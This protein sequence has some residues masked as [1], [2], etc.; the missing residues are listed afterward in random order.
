MLAPRRAPERMP[1]ARRGAF[2]SAAVM[3]P[4][5]RA[6]AE[7][8][9]RA[10]LF[11]SDRMAQHGRAL[12]ASH[13]LASGR[14]P[15]RLLN[16]LAANEHALADA[17]RLLTIAVAENRRITPAGEW[18]LDNFYLIEEQ[19][20]TARRHLPKDYSRE[21]PRL[22]SGP[23]AG[24]PRVYDIALEAVAHGD[25]R[26][27]GESLSRFVAA[28][29]TVTVLKLGELWAIPIMLRLALIENLRR[30][31]V[32]IAA[33][34]VERDLADA[35]AERMTQTIETDPKNLILVVADMA[36]SHPPMSCTFVAEL[37][38][39]VQHRGPALALPL[40]WIEQQL[41]E[42]GLSIEQSIQLENQQQ[43]ADQV[44]I[45][46]S[47]GSL[48]LL[49]AMDWRTFVETLSAVELALR[50]DPAGIYRGMDFSTR[51]RYRHAVE[52]IA[53]RCALAEEEVARKAVELA[54]AGAAIDDPGAAADRTAHVGHYLIDK[55]LPALERAVVVR[56]SAAG[57]VRRIAAC[58]PLAL[59]LGAIAL[60][61]ALI[62]AGLLQQLQAAPVLG[63]A[64]A[65]MLLPPGI[66]A[67]L[68][69]S[70][71]GVALTNWLATLLVTPH[72]LPRMDFAAGIPPCWRTLVVVPT[73]LTSAEDVDDLI[74]ALEV[75]FLANRDQSLHFGLL[76]DLLDAPC[77]TLPEDGAL[78]QHARTGV[79]ALNRKYAHPGGAA[80]GDVFFL[81]HR[82]RR[83]NPQEGVWMGYERKRGK[84]T[85]LNALL[86]GGASAAGVGFALVV[87]NTASLAAVK[88]V[89]TLD[90][91]T[92]LPR[93]TARQLV[94][95]MAHPL[96]RPRYDEAACR[97]VD[98]YGILQPSVEVSL[99]G[100]NR[101]RYARLFG[102]EA[103]IDPYTHAVSDVYQDVFG[104]GS[105]IGKGIYD[106]DA[107]EQAVGGRFPENRIL[108]HDLLEGCYARAGRLSEVQLYED[109]P[110]TYCADV[111]RRHRW[112]RGDWQ[113]AGWLWRQ[114]PCL[115]AGGHA[116]P[117]ARLER[118]PLSAL[119]QWKLLDNLR[120]GLVPAA[121]VL[122]LL[123]GWT[124]LSPAGPWTLSVI[125]LLL[126]PAL[127]TLAVEL[128]RKAEEVRLR[129]HLATVAHSAARRF[130]QL[131]FELAC[132]PYEA[133]FSLDAIVRTLWRMGVTHRRLLEW[134]PSREAER[135]LAG[136]G[137]SD[138]GAFVRT[139]WVAPVV[140]AGGAMLVAL[141]NPAGVGVAAP[142]LLLW[143]AAPALAWWI[144]R[145]LAHRAPRLTAEQRLFLRGLSRRTWAFFDTFV[146]P[147]DHWLP[148]D[149][150]QEYRTAL[151]AHRTSP[152]NIGL[153]LLANLAAY[154]FGYLSAGRLAERTANT[155]RT[156]GTLERHR[157]H[158]YNWYDTQTLLPLLPRYI[159]TVDSGNL[160]GHLLTLRAGLL[161]L[162]NDPIVPV[163]LADGLS[164]TFAIVAGTD[165][166]AAAALAAFRRELAA[167]AAAPVGS[168]ATLRL[169]LLRLASAAAELVPLAAGKHLV[170][171]ANVPDSEAHDWA[172]ALVR[173]CREALDEVDFLAPWLALLA[174]P[175]SPKAGAGAAGSGAGF[176][177]DAP[178]PSLRA[179]AE[180]EREWCPAIGRR[181]EA[182]TNAAQRAWFGELRGHVAKGSAR[183]R[184]RLAVIEGLVRQADALAQVEYDFLFD[185]TRHLLAIGYNVTEGWAESSYYDLLASE[186]RLSTFVGIAQ[187]QL[188]Q[189]SWFALGRLL[190]RSAGEPVLLSWS[191]S[192]FEYLMPLLVM[193]SYDNSLLHQTCKAAVARQIEYGRQRGVPWGIS[194]SA[195]NTV[196]V[197]LNY[198]YRAFGV[199]GLG[200]KRGLADDLVVAPYASALALM[201]A[202]EAACVNLQRLGG[203]GLLGR[204]GLFEAVDYTPARQRRGQASVVVRSFMAHHQGM[205]LLALAHLLLDR[206]MQ[207]RFESDRQF[208]AVLLLLQERI[209]R[210]MALFPHTAQLSHMHSAAPPAELPIRT[211]DRA[212]TPTPEVQL[213]SNGRYHV[214]L[215]HAG[216]GYSRWKDLAVTRWREDGTCDNWGVFCYVRDVA[217]GQFWS[218]AHQPTL[219]RAAC[220]EAIFSEGRAEFRRRDALAGAEGAESGAEGRAAGGEGKIETYTEIAVSPED[221]IELRRVR[222]TNRSSQ[223]RQIELTTYAEVVIA[224]PAADALHPAF[225]K[226][227]VHTEIV[228]ERHAILC[229]RR[230]RSHGERAPWM[231]HLVAVRGEGG[232]A[233]DALSSVSY[234]SDRLRFIGRGGSAAAPRAM[235]E[236][237][238]LSDSEGPVL[239]PIVAIRCVLTLDPE[240]SAT[241]DVV[242]GIADCREL[243]ECLIDK[244][245]DRHLADRVF[246]MSWTHSQVVLRQIDASEADAQL[247]ARLASGVIFANAALR[248]DA[249]VLIG[250]RRGQSGLWGYAISGD[251]PIVLLQIGDAA[252]IDLVRQLVKAHAYWHLKGL[253]VD[254][255]IWNEE[256]AGYRQRLQEQIMGLIASGIGASVIDRPGGVFVRLAEQIA[257]EDRV[258]LQAVARVVITDGRGTL[259]EQLDHRL[260]AAAREPAFTPSRPSHME[261]SPRGAPVDAVP[262][263]DLILCNGLGGFSADGREYVIELAPGQLAPAPW[264]NVLANPSFGTV[265]SESGGAYTWSENA[266]EFRLTPW[267]NDPVGD[268]GG[269]A[270]YLRDEET[271]EVWSPTPLPAPAAVPYVVRHGFGYSVFEMRAHGIAAELWVYV[272]ADAAVKFSLLK[273]H[274]ESGR[275]RRLSVTAYVEWVL[276]DLR[277]KSAMHVS[278]AFDAGSGALC[279]RNPFNSEFAERVAFLDVDEP[280]RNLSGDRREFIGRNGS[281]RS[282]AA[283]R[284]SRLSGKVGAGLDPCAAIQ[285]SVDLAA[286]QA[287][288]IVFRLGVGCDADDA[289]RLVRRFRGAA[290][291]AQALEAVRQQ[292]SRSLGAV[293]VDTPEPEI[294]VLANGWLLYQTLACRVWARSGHYQSGGAFGFRDQL[295]DVMALVHAE[296]ELVRA[297][298]LLCAS[299]QFREGDVQHW[300][301]PPAG[302]GVRTQCSDDYL[303]LPLAVCR[304]VNTTGD[305]AVLDERTPFLEGRPVQPEEDSYYDLPARSADVA[306]LY[307]HCVHAIRHGLRF[308]ERGLPLIGS[309]D[310]ND[311]MNL[312]GIKGK[313]E[314]VWLGFF[315]CEVLRCFAEVAR[316]Y[317]DADFAALCLREGAALRDRIEA[318]G[319]DGEW[320]RRAWFDDGTP[321]GSAANAECRIDSI[322]QSW[323]VLSG[324]GDDAR[325]RRAMRA[326]DAYLVRRDDG[327]V[328]LLGPP[329]DKS[330]LDP[331]YIRGYLPG[332]RENG[333][334]Y[335]HGAVWVAMA[336]A[337]LGEGERAWALLRLINP[338]NHARS[339]QGVAT[340]KIEPYVV[341]ADV[342]ALAPHAG[343]GGWSWY[344]GSAGWMYRLVTE[345]LLGIRREGAQLRL[346]PCLPVDWPGF[347]IHYRYGETTYHIAVLRTAA[348]DGEAGAA[349]RVRLDGVLRAD[350]TIALADDGRE[351]QVE[352]EL[353]HAVPAGSRTAAT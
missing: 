170:R 102:G 161:A 82:S 292:W 252:N 330:E 346:A 201:V 198:Q 112:I 66:L 183:A 269:E 24:H 125:G 258:L 101:S 321:L 302:R 328:Q 169:S 259:A 278:T 85:E 213:L 256:H 316:A 133:F 191:G 140:A 203:A 200:L 31:S 92:Q 339:A 143:L 208:Q 2:F 280:T 49:G 40:S 78:V 192:M 337:A 164:D 130:A 206:P 275:R 242:S 210:V 71:L 47:I 81:F 175:A 70:H 238:P 240:Q 146:G 263:R 141:A 106:V 196:D 338:V 95:A 234:E 308:G 235:S 293:R 104:E 336:F 232:A 53:R 117:G 100:A 325:S 41:A 123:S 152:T 335:T 111:S 32:R 194:E 11:S 211:F 83:W 182:E 14:V 88:F 294:D 312:V 353:P 36:R 8:P 300:W 113:L 186:A 91:D 23:S 251:L 76:T 15:D 151:V 57:A 172:Q 62:G 119:S 139:M 297:H 5:D 20:R 257:S 29:Q 98:G 241:I 352:V 350:G 178:V 54:R 42:A 314:S 195:Y 220:Y 301:H 52:A 284:R 223:R 303:W 221:D 179:L 247:H 249:A 290:A 286:E 135:T 56:T 185:S 225:S 315:L 131:G 33:G 153:A 199:P 114:A 245:Q 118:N 97:V 243:A 60:I 147:E 137:R 34:S 177:L 347:G 110:A 4:P 149:N 216:G 61:T 215:T 167:V 311:G 310:W 107:F 94:G 159:S 84:L 120:R 156:M 158:F 331:G 126:L 96:N 46:N 121:L 324:A 218:A 65:W 276:G 305:V 174:D 39:R 288:E 38:R 132:L 237:G 64:L 87:G 115:R 228:R 205:S 128:L 348:G 322:S 260:P 77:E 72:A 217:S 214:M 10:E 190:T 304:Y 67:L 22:A 86:R 50:E 48:R 226:L 222:I 267:N 173:Q 317:G 90:T 69:A 51:D 45:S 291:A 189:E 160:A 28:Y 306:S 298:L 309:G 349:P 16:R 219:K 181:L 103:G 250:N 268:L 231:L 13:R 74:E 255:V 313:G 262:R 105:F 307:E 93:D 342:Y 281:L 265:V 345:S 296:P 273:L 63:G 80:A 282:P 239:D 271:G 19:I 274:N 176:V 150:F 154:D 209:P 230:P 319:W 320:Y 43:A 202:P 193:P 58:F 187:G 253:A 333:G 134:N 289:G 25:G 163:R 142:V 343:R 138:L 99:P 227:F 17:S 261:A 334:Q 341:A 344:T 1:G 109:Y 270:L 326:V 136:R 59:Y 55:G 9:L 122:L 332:V 129:Q 124:V 264:V 254:L 233:A 37:V 184:A 144:S 73:M 212:D 204:F 35:W 197:H 287:R 323:S 224:P 21:L 246:D 283:L 318:Q 277:S 180:L 166:I 171:D 44:S 89:L 295:Q 236:P 266:H 229:T 127:C 165:G 279:A 148:P 68:A 207:R 30:A 168:L 162:G 12:A 7:P 26:V 272:A 327:L 6:D 145:P 248:A 79:E 116:G 329:F 3:P 285:V 188:P 75:R 27:D 244:Y 340:Y 351:H 18:L 108:S 155:L 299:R 157:G